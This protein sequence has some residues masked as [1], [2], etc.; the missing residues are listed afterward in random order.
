MPAA[1]SVF[2]RLR[3]IQLRKIKA[4]LHQKS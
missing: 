1:V 4:R 3:N 2:G